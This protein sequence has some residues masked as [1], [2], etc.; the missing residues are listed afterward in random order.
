MVFGIEFD[1]FREEVTSFM[2]AR[3]LGLAMLL[4]HSIVKSLLSEG[5]VAL[6]FEFVGHSRDL[7]LCGELAL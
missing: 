6:S 1:R 7:Q 4:L 2:L 5:F 3:S